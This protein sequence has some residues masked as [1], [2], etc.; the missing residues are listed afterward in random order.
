MV[1]SMIVLIKKQFPF[2]S[3]SILTLTLHFSYFSYFSLVQFLCKNS[4]DVT[5]EMK[6]LKTLELLGLPCRAVIKQY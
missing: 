4:R 3:I 6:I 1:L 2:E 5:K